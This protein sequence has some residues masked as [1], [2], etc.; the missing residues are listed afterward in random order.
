MSDEPKSPRVAG[1]IPRRPY[2]SPKIQVVQMA[3]QRDTLVVSDFG[4][5]SVHIHDTA[6][7][8]C[9]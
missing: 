8:N 6:A 2:A 1:Q 9:L 7:P 3:T 4:N 5:C